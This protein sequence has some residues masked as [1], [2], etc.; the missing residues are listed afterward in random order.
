MFSCEYC[1]VLKKTYF[2]E[3]LRTVAS[4]NFTSSL[5]FSIIHLYNIIS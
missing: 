4:G 3:Y 5:R 2:E 1:E